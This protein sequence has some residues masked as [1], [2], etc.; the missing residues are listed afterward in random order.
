MI[1][2][3]LKGKKSRN[4]IHI[5]YEVVGL[6]HHLIWV[7][8]LTVLL[9][10]I[11]TD[12]K[13]T[14]NTIMGSDLEEDDLPIE[15]DTP[16]EDASSEEAS[17]MGETLP[18]EDETSEALE[19]SGSTGVPKNIKKVK[20]NK[21][22]KDF[23]EWVKRYFSSLTARRCPFA[24]FNI[25]D[26]KNIVILSNTEGGLFSV[27]HAGELSFHIIE[28]KDK[29]DY[30]NRLK[31]LLM[32]GDTT[33]ELRKIPTWLSW[34]NKC[35]LDPVLIFHCSVKN[36]F[37]VSHLDL[38]DQEY[39]K[40]Q[41]LGFKYEDFII[42]NRLVEWAQYFNKI[43]QTY[44]IYMEEKVDITPKMENILIFEHIDLNK[45]QQDGKPVYENYLPLRVI[46]FDGFSTPSLKEFINK[47][48]SEY[49]YVRRIWSETP[50]CLRTMTYFE[51]PDVRIRSSRPNM[52]WYPIPK[53]D[54]AI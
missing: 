31:E 44:P 29:L 35:G 18:D 6:T 40:K 43:E 10:P 4:S 39:H 21:E 34:V 45:L 37:V 15:C 3:S 13:Y 49:T 1:L 22:D 33:I 5:P 24:Y 47:T 11:E 12:T 51:D 25:F 50:G 30:L 14:G 7:L 53:G 52:G 46:S 42:V 20:I 8:F 36:V 26:N 16:T 9:N 32:I 28:F 2:F 19:V 41:I 48:K 38:A 54:R 17:I 23:L 27:F